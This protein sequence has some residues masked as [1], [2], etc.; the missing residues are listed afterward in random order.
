[1][2]SL[3]DLKTQSLL[4]QILEE[5]RA[6]RKELAETSAAPSLPNLPPYIPVGPHNPPSEF[7]P[8]QCGKCGIT[9]ST[10]MGYACPDPKCPTGLGP[11]TC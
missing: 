3:S 7:P 8:R 1:M 5:L 6:I 10:V 2:P 4:E 9:L 11:S